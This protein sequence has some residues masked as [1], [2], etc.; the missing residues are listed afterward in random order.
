[1]AAEDRRVVLV[2]E[3]DRRGAGGTCAARRG[4]SRR[5]APA[6][7]G[8]PPGSRWRHPQA[9]HR[10]VGKLTQRL[11]RNGGVGDLELPPGTRPSGPPNWCR[12]VDV[13]DCGL[14]AR[15]R[16]PSVC[17]AVSVRGVAHRPARGPQSWRRPCPRRT[18]PARWRGWRALGAPSHH[19]PVDGCQPPAG[20]QVA[21]VGP[22]HDG[23]D[24]EA[25]G[26]RSCVPDA[27]TAITGYG[28]AQRFGDPTQ[29][30]AASAVSRS[31]AAQ[32]ERP[33]L[34]EQRADNPGCA[35]AAPPR[36]GVRGPPRRRR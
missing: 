31:S 9:P 25:A 6:G 36:P 14:N 4:R 7:P 35:C 17:Q 27:R 29:L 28:S 22:G 20:E 11:D 32:V 1:M 12:G 2:A 21:V 10:E 18:G 30:A 26:S 33:E 16:V 34:I 3:A 15:S 23:V 8:R 19:G 13:L 24:E 5:P